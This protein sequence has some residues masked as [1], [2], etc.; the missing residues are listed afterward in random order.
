MKQK[1]D[2][3]KV[4][5]SSVEEFTIDYWR[6]EFNRLFKL[7]PNFKRVDLVAFDSYYLTAI[8]KDDIQN[9]KLGKAGLAKTRRLVLA[10]QKMSDYLSDKELSTQKLIKRQKLITV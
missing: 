1:N 7:H 3:V 10:L 4:L 6:N 2:T 8:G 5:D 9:I